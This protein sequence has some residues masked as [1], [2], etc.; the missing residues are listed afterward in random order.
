MQVDGSRPGGD[1]PIEQHRAQIGVEC[2][3]C[4]YR[5]FVE[6]DS[7]LVGTFQDSKVARVIHGELQAW[8]VSRCP[9][10]LRMISTISRN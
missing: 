4:H 7:D 8:M 2:P 5:Q 1:D 6:V 3:Q 9:E 10:H